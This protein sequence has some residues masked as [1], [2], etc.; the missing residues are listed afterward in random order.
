MTVHYDVAG[1]VATVRIDRPEVL[2]ALNRPT[3]E[4][5]RD[6]FRRASADHAVGVV[7]LTGTGER[8]F[9]TGA[10]LDEQEAFLDRPNDYWDWMNRFIEAIESIKDC[11]KPVVARL[12]G[13]TVGGGNELNL[14]CDIAVAADDIVLRHVGPSRGSLPAGGATQWM[15][16]VVGDRR[17]REV[18]LLNRPFSAQQ[19]LEW[20]WVN[21][22]VP[23]AELDAAVQDYCTELL[24]KMPEIVRATRVQ[25]NFWKDYSWAMTVKMAREWLTVHAASDEVAEGLAAFHQKRPVDYERLRREMVEAGQEPARVAEVARDLDQEVHDV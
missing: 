11:A 22:V 23:R 14:A 7:V 5:L 24:A 10:D 1:G 6:S 2:N 20:G 8:A 21:R 13:M 3:L 15:P 9:C 19:A 12:N 17:A 16:L 18:M 4:A 25:L